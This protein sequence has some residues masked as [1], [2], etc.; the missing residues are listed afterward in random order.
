MQMQLK[1]CALNSLVSD[2]TTCMPPS[3]NAQ[4]PGKQ[5]RAGVPY[6]HRSLKPSHCSS[7]AEVRADRDDCLIDMREEKP[8]E[9]G[10]LGCFLQS[11]VRSGQDCERWIKRPR[12][13]KFLFY[14]V[15]DVF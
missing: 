12:A 13:A 7:E 11:V 2:P 5:R 3:R 1:C 14:C 8:V 10:W 15:V 4:P 9:K 6:C